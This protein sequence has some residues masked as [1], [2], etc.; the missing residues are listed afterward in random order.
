L[1]SEEVQVGLICTNGFVAL[2]DFFFARLKA[3]SIIPFHQNR[4]EH[5][6]PRM[7]RYQFLIL[8]LTAI[9]S[10]EGADRKFP[11]SELFDPRQ[12]IVRISLIS[13]PIDLKPG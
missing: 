1:T 6:H 11:F 12:R 8:E 10:T 13:A 3:S 5:S 4:R 7:P 2:P 9:N